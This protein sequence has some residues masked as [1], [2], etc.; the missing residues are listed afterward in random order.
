MVEEAQGYKLERINQSK[1]DADR[2]NAVFAEYMKA[3]EVTR[4]R[5]YLETMDDIL[6]NVEKKVITDKEI[7]GMLPLF[8]LSEQ[9]GLK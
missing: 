9:G 7:M 1:G 5:I 3:P 8:N 4:K 6:R 2:F